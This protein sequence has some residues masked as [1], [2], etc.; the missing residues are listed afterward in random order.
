M[1]SNLS[2]ASSR[3]QLFAAQSVS[4]V[5][6]RLEHATRSL[7][8]LA[9]LSSCMHPGA[10]SRAMRLH[11]SLPHEKQGKVMHPDL[12]NE[13]LLKAQYTVRGELYLAAEALRKAG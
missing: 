11:S 3:I 8:G 4:A 2:R 7:A 13:S 10:Q 9:R 5:M 1:A 6:S 12:F